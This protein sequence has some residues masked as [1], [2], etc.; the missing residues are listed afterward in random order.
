ML[1]L[2]Q[3]KK[4]T[5]QSNKDTANNKKQPTIYKT[6]ILRVHSINNLFLLFFFLG[7]KETKPKTKDQLQFF[8]AQKALAMPP[9]KM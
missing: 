2:A 1:L 7:K 3:L 4:P 5:K 6:P 8:I 9:K